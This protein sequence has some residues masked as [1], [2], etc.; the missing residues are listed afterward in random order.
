MR[1]PAQVPALPL[2]ELGGRGMA[3]AAMAVVAT[4]AAPLFEAWFSS[5]TH[6]RGRFSVDGAAVEEQRSVAQ[7]ALPRRYVQRAHSGG[8]RSRAVFK[9]E[10]I[11]Q[12]E[13]LLKPGAVCLDLGAAPGAWSQYARARVGPGPGRGVRHPAD[14]A[15]RGS[16]VR[17]GDFRED[18]VFRS[19]PGRCCR[20]AGS[21]WS[22]R[23]W[24][25]PSAAWT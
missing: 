11:D 17:A 18:E 8:W 15:A 5:P 19:C 9:L 7:G 2:G 13:R 22:C 14:G 3:P 10:E 25:R 16:R 6:C 4:A 12:R 21:T 20:K 24:P 1:E 23:T